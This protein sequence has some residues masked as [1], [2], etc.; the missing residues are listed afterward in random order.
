MH[1]ALQTDGHHY[2]ALQ[3]ADRTVSA[4]NSQYDF[5]TLW[6]CGNNEETRRSNTLS[7]QMDGF[8]SVALS[9]DCG[10]LVFGHNL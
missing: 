1:T 7:S 3:I 6:I 5:M 10:A 9:L 8:L 2:D 4:K